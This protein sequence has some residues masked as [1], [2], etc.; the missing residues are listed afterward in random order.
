MVERT[1]TPLRETSAWRRLEWHLADVRHYGLPDLFDGD[2]TRGERLAGEAAGLYLDYSKHLLTDETLELLRKLAGERRLRE[3]AAVLLR[4]VSEDPQATR[5]LALRLPHGRSLLVEGEDVAREAHEERDRMYELAERVRSGAWRGATGARIRA[6]VELADGES[7]LGT[8]LAYQA[9]RAS[10]PGDLDCRSVPSVDPT[11]LAGALQGLEPRETLLVVVAKS[12]DEPPTKVLTAAA[13]Q[14]LCAS[15]GTT[16]SPAPHVLLVTAE[17]DAG[18]ADVPAE[19]VLRIPRWL[20]E[21]RGLCS[22]AGLSVCLALGPDGFEE[23][24]SGLHAMDEH[25][26]STPLGGN[27]PAIAGLIAVWYRGFLGAQSA[28]ILPYAEPLRLLPAYVRHLGATG[29]GRT[30]AGDPVDAGAAPLLWGESGS[31]VRDGFLELLHHGTALCPAD[32][33]VVG[34]SVA[35]DPASHDLLAATALAEA[36]ALAFGRT[37]EELEDAG[38]EPDE[39]LHRILPGNRPTSVLLL[40][41]LR[42][43]TLGA[44]LSFYE[45]SVFTQAAIWE[46]DPF[47]RRDVE[48]EEALVARL[49]EELDPGWRRELMHDSSTNALVRRYRRLRNARD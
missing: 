49:A 3:R 39:S 30:A 13:L 28:A 12:P 42:P 25:F 27:L 46:S 24:C 36:E 11:A 17:P 48:Y 6:V 9:L 19:N 35:G 8:A 31:R 40:P 43:E 4:G 44:L 1:R 14:W 33:V 38:V 20:D 34:R 5:H 2:P 32:F 15:L 29:V 41:S 22:A 47:A 7:R 23:L 18:L 26:T 21:R 10:S 45:H 37:A 16:V